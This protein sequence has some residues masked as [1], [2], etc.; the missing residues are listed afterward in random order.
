MS[1]LWNKAIKNRE[2]WVFNYDIKIHGKFDVWLDVGDN[3]D[4]FEILQDH[5]IYNHFPN[6]SELTT[7]A[8]LSKNL[9]TN[10]S[11]ASIHPDLYYPRTYDFG[12]QKQIDEFMQDFYRTALMSSL[13][14]HAEYFWK[15]NKDALEF[16]DS[17]VS[18]IDPGVNY[19]SQYAAL[20]RQYKKMH[21][22][23]ELWKNTIPVNQSINDNYDYDEGK[24][25][26]FGDEDIEWDD[27]INTISHIDHENINN[28][29]LG[30]KTDCIIVNV[31][32]LK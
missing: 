11:E 3:N 8:G 31:A 1:L 17:Q 25:E 23:E 16:I 20:E 27:N 5:Q 15:S 29:S 21:E 12:E 28:F 7:K 19:K 30:D 13:K 10:I 4:I 18:S 32:L 26:D 24:E 6:N 2:N 9:L 14:K 22:F